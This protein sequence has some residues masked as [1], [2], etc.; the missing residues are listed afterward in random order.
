MSSR[1]PVEL[2]TFDSPELELTASMR[3]VGTILGCPLLWDDAEHQPIWPD[4][5]PETIVY[6]ADGSITI[7]ACVDVN[8]V[9]WW[10]K[11]PRP[12]D[13]EHTVRGGDLYVT[14]LASGAE[15]C[16]AC[17]VRGG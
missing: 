3:Y 8:R 7:D 15:T 4:G 6:E 10:V 13:C 16:L 12:L 11:Q 9:V 17:A 1:Y 14:W 2:H 5:W